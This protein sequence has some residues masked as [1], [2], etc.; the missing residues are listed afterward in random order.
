[1]KYFLILLTLFVFVSCA[2]I[3]GVYATY[4]QGAVL[5]S[6]DPD[7]FEGQYCGF[8]PGYTAAICRGQATSPSKNLNDYMPERSR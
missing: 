4:P 1:M 2:R 7:C 3:E 6:K 5:C 8:L